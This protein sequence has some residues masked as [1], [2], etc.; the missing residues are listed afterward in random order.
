MQ[1]LIK[2]CQAI[3]ELVG[4]SEQDEIDSCPNLGGNEYYCQQCPYYNNC[5]NK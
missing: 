4:Y 2:I 5:Q 1:T 3:G